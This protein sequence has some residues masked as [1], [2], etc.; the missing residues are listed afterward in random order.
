MIHFTPRGF[1]LLF[2]VALLASPG[3][4]QE[5]FILDKPGSMFRK[6]ERRPQLPIKTRYFF[7]TSPST[8]REYLRQQDLLDPKGRLKSSGVF[9]DDGNKAG[10]IKYTYDAAGVLQKKELRKLGKNEV[11]ITYLN[12]TGLPLKIE[13]RTKTDSL[14]SY[15]SYAYDPKGNLLEESFYKGQ[16]LHRKKQFD[17]LYNEQGKPTQ[18]YS[19][20]FDS[21][22]NKLPGASTFAVHE[23]DDKGMILQTTEYKDKE[24]RKMLNWV[25]FKY[26]LDND[27]RVIRQSGFNEEQAEISRMEIS[28][29]DSSIKY[30]AFGLC[31]CPAKNLEPGISGEYVYNSFGELIRE[32]LFQPNG[33][34]SQTI[35]YRYD[36]F[37]NR[38]DTLIEKN[39]EPG[40]VNRSKVLIEVYTDQ[41]K[42]AR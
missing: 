19:C 20:E 3:K 12:P 33:Q 8:G 21:A 18:T 39:A 1:F 30:T 10:D 9:S 24:K 6:N 27:Y 42:I 22:G 32:R 2:T 4:A 29:T 17:N 36:D 14:I 41:A 35:S 38:V 34:L 13:T 31:K 7:E 16:N 37:G 25:Y 15:T 40:R 28:Y 26:Q 5:G 11:E 23:Y